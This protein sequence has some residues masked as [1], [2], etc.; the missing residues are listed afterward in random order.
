MEKGPKGKEKGLQGRKK[1]PQEK[2]KRS[3]EKKN[4]SYLIELEVEA[5]GEQDILSILHLQF[6][7][8]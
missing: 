4:P 5:Q 3:H 8:Q 2:E 1:R 6:T 7:I